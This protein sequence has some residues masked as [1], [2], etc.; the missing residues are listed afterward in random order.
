MI[1]N[2]DF[3]T[4]ERAR[5]LSHSSQNQREKIFNEIEHV[6]TEMANNGEFSVKYESVSFNNN[7]ALITSV[8]EDLVLLGYKVLK[9]SMGI[10]ISW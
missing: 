5:Q 6:I 3:I 10:V 9:D 8:K 1:T 4:A 7:E 2:K